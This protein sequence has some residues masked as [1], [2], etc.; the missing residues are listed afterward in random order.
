MY[1]KVCGLRKAA[2]V[3]AAVAA[4]ADAIGFVLT[5]SPR[6]LTPQAV[7]E[8][9]ALVPSGTAATV[10]VFRG[11]PLDEVRRATALAGVDTV[12]LHGEEEPEAFAALR[13]EGLRLIR[14]TSPATGAPLETGAYGEDLLIVDSPRPG[15]GERWDPAALGTRPTGS[16]MLAG[17]L[18]PDNVA[19]AVTGLRPWG[20]DVSSGVEISRGVKDIGLIER[21]IAAAKG[22]GPLPP[23]AD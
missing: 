23:K 18:A 12:Q 5:P 1:V 2:E 9:A 17:G 4:G 11:E 14:A 10:A 3:E 20:V 6:Q 15:S 7:R 13:A 22:T 16:W 21:F 8:L 19:D